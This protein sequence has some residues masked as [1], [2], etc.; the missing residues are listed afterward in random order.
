M[1]LLFA[2]HND[3]NTSLHTLDPSI[4]QIRSETM[5]LP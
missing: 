1:H 2:A 5:P 3:N 4:S